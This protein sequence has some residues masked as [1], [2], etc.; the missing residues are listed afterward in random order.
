[1]RLTESKG[2]FREALAEARRRGGPVGLVLT[3]G[4]LHEGHLALIAAVR[5][6]TET[7]AVTVFVNPLQFPDPADLERYPRDL[8]RDGELAEAAGADILFAPSPQEIYPDGVPAVVVDPGPLG[9]VLEGAARPGHF[10]GVATV[11]TKLFSLAG[12]S[13]S[14]F[15]EKDYQQLLV[16]RRLVT[17]LE[18]P[19]ELLPVATVRE[20]DGLACSSRNARLSPAER[21]AAAALYRSLLAGGEELS[22]G[23]GVEAA[24][25]TMRESLEKEPLVRTDYAV[26]RRPDDLAPLPPG[27][28]GPARLLVAAQVGPVRLID[29]L[30]AE[31]P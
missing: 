17:D 4:G 2:S 5:E 19:I 18:L 8:T 1:M 24:E 11:V 31:V 23:A 9:S 26:V 20:A 3:M 10:R 15:G 13:L 30:A 28:R 29:N 27:H 12:S 22:G 16:V 21:S 14:A 25:K 6:R 7:V